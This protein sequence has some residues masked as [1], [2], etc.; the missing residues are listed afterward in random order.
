MTRR[1]AKLTLGKETVR[2]LVSLHE[3]GMA[4]TGPRCE[5][6]NFCNTEVSVCMPC[7]TYDAACTA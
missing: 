5:S 7:V 2:R 4:A 6:R 3:A 1:N